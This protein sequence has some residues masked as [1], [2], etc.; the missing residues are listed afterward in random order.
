M[1]VVNLQTPNGCLPNNPC[2][3]NG[4][5]IPVYNIYVCQCP[6]GFTGVNC[7]ELVKA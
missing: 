5:C 6:A 3:N 2:L 1:D 7:E 4:E